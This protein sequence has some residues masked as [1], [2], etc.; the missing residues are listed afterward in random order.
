MQ[1]VAR[2]AKTR[3]M[4]NEEYA[5]THFEYFSAWRTY[6]KKDK[7]LRGKI[8]V[9]T[10]EHAEV[11]VPFLVDALNM[12]SPC[13]KFFSMYFGMVIMTDKIA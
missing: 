7:H 1:K 13:C 9:G 5:V 11:F 10:L 3:K 12:F 8:L 4:R 2:R 6:V